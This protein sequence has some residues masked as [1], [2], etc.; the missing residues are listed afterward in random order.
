MEILKV[1]FQEP[2]ASQKFTRSLKETGF[3]VITNHGIEPGLITEVYEEWIRYFS[4]E[5]K[6]KDK[7]DPHTQ[8]GYFPF[9]SENA[10]NSEVKDLK[11]FYHIYPGKKFPTQLSQKTWVLYHALLKLGSE[12]LCWI[13]QETPEPIRKHYSMPLHEMIEGSDRNLFR[14]IHYPPLQGDEPEGSIRAAAHED[15]NLI[16][17]LPA[18]TEMGLQV[19]SSLGKWFD[20]PGNFGDIVINVGDMLQMAS[21]SYYRSTTHQVINPRGEAAKISR[22]SMPLFVHP[23]DKVKLSAQLTAG[24]YLDQR[25]KEIGLKS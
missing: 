11:E 7:F 16:T 23:K 4:S 13:D 3:G 12:L 20:V 2:Q 14:I 24:D 22:Y 21:D 25:L 1:N 18:S 19:K 17:L 5:D 9:G 8:D 15:I 10:K 6:F